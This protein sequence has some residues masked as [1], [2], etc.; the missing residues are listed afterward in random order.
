[1]GLLLLVLWFAAVIGAAPELLSFGNAGGLHLST[2]LLVPT[3]VPTRFDES[4]LRFVAILMLPL[5]WIV[6]NFRLWW[7]KEV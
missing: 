1:M 3:E 6:G 2:D 5:I 4:P 7:A